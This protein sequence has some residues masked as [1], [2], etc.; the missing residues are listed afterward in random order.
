VLLTEAVREAAVEVEQSE[1][2]Q[3]VDE[4]V[5]QVNKKKRK[6]KEANAGLILP[7]D[8]K[9]SVIHQTLKPP[10]PSSKP[11]PMSKNKLKLMM[12]NKDPPRRGGLQDFLKQ[13]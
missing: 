12:A 7:Q 9:K 8:K 3:E 10:T 6:P 13:L 5:V 1:Q 2:P 4:Q 11:S